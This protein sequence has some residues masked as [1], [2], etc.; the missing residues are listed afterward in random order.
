MKIHPNEIRRIVNE[1][2]PIIPY[3]GSIACFILGLT[4]PIMSSKKQILN[5]IVLDF[6]DIRLVD[7]IEIF[8]KNSDYLLALVILI[9]TIIVPLI[10][11]IAILPKIIPIYS[12]PKVLS[13]ILHKVDKWNMLD[14]F[15][16]AIILV[17]FKMDS[18]IIVMKIKIGTTFLIISIITR[19]WVMTIL[20]K[21]G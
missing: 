17:I 7:S 15:L 16:V 18:S 10:K 8:Y 3:F 2:P 5:L 14:V 1:F 21:R 13:S 4:F 11:Y 12:F 20:D 9:F 19:M 6:K